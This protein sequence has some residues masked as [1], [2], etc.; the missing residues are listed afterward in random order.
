MAPAAAVRTMMPPSLRLQR[1]GQLA[2]PLALAVGQPPRHARSPRRAGESTRKRPAIDSSIVTRGA[3][4]AHRVLDDLDEHLLAGLQE[5]VDLAPAARLRVLAGDDDVVDVE[6][7]VAGQAEVD[8]RRLHAAQDVVDLALVDVAGQRALAA[9][10]DQRLDGTA[11]LDHRHPQLGQVDRDQ[12]GLR[13]VRCKCQ[14]RTPTGWSRRQMRVRTS[15]LMFAVAADEAGNR[16][17]NLLRAGGAGSR[18][19][20][21][22]SAAVPARAR[23]SSSTCATSIRR[24]ALP[25][26]VRT[27]SQLSASANACKRARPVDVVLAPPPR[28]RS[29]PRGRRPSGLRPARCRPRSCRAAAARRAARPPRP[30]RDRPRAARRPGRPAP[31]RRPPAASRARSQD[32]ASCPSTGRSRS[33]RAAARRAACQRF[34][35]ATESAPVRQPRR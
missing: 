25:G 13:Y 20:E 4:G 19:S 14:V 16:L 28:R 32:A 9:A 10:L 5:L 31:A 2:Q 8:E 1:L 29:P 34:R 26:A 7:P 30:G 24:S 33:R 6:E 11:L 3:L 21:A 18:S 17:C 12:D 22:P 15:R 35:G 27:T 23:C